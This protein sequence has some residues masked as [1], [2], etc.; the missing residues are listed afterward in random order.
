[1]TEPQP[2]E[3][4]GTPV[5]AVFEQLTG[6]E[7]AVVAGAVLVIVTW[8]FGQL[9]I[10]DYS[11]DDLALP[12]S[13]GILG[14]VYSYFSGGT[15]TWHSLYP[16]IVAVVALGIAILGLNRFFEDFRFTY[17]G[18]SAW[19]WRILYYAGAGLLGYGGV[20]LLS[21]R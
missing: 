20:S 13:V 8:F 5:G 18:G 9:L 11:I 2:S 6:A 4:K 10:N 16:W 7:R 17:L 19:L 21:R 3:P 1:M 15:A 12:L 14:A